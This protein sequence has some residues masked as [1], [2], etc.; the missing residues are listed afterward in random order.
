MII[1]PG[2]SLAFPGGRPPR[3]A[4]EHPWNVVGGLRHAVT[5]RA[6]GSLWEAR[7]GRV[8]APVGVNGML[9]RATAMG[10]AVVAAASSSSSLYKI[11]VV[12]PSEPINSYMM[13]ALQTVMTANGGQGPIN[14][15]YSTGGFKI[16]FA[17]GGAGIQNNPNGAANTLFN[18][19][20]L[21][22]TYLFIGVW[23]AGG[24]NAN[25]TY[26]VALNL[27][28]GQVEYSETAGPTQSVTTASDYYG[29]YTYDGG[30]TDRHLF[31]AGALFLNGG[32]YPSLEALLQSL[33]RGN[34]FDF[35]YE[36]AAPTIRTLSS[37]NPSNTSATLTVTATD[38]VESASLSASATVPNPLALAVTD[39]LDVAH[40]SLSVNVYLTSFAVN[41]AFDTASVSLTAGA[42]P[43]PTGPAYPP[44]PG[45][46]P[47]D[48]VLVGESPIG[49]IPAFSPWEPVVSQ[50]ANSPQIDSLVQSWTAMVDPTKNLQNFFDNIWNIGQ[51]VN[52]YGLDV[53]SR[54]VGLKNGRVVTAL[55]GDY[56]GFAE[57]RPDEGGV[58]TWNFGFNRGTFGG[59]Q[60]YNGEP[61]T[62]NYTLEDEPFLLLI[63]AKAASNIT[64]GAIPAVNQILLNLFPNRGNCYVQEVF[65]TSQFFGF[66]E[67]TPGG[68]DILGF[69]QA[70][71]YNGQN[72]GVDMQITYVFKFQLTPVELAIITT[73]GVL[74]TAAGVRATIVQAI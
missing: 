47:I 22:H 38:P 9:G 63:M 60:F 66:A 49:E 73:E 41:D 21:G 57:A 7:S 59:G 27:T 30:T 11:P 42:G 24:V 68:S 36:P 65:A 2:R 51:G 31:H 10:P 17:A 29:V 52:G 13:V 72:I 71:F 8:I 35:W 46:A 15:N 28:T 61:L 33:E 6:D 4:R 12:V 39:A 45:G 69:N 19:T 44:A 64:S 5:A 56:F 54:I 3:L 18:P 43:L 58:S 34:P 20:V 26:A 53:W 16:N 23:R 25:R 67:A 40:V 48:D 62:E 74:P 70:E 1:K 55:Q 14:I 32:G 37:A 50:Y